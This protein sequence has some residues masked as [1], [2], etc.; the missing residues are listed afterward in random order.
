M[1][2][3]NDIFICMELV[4]RWKAWKH[5]CHVDPR[6]SDITPHLSAS[7][8]LFFN[9]FLFLW[10]LAC[11]N[12]GFW[13]AFLGNRGHGGRSMACYGCA[14]DYWFG[15]MLSCRTWCYSGLLCAFGRTDNSLG[16]GLRS[17]VSFTAWLGLGYSDACILR[18]LR[19]FVLQPSFYTTVRFTAFLICRWRLCFCSAG[20]FECFRAR[21]GLP[22]QLCW[23]L[24]TASILPQ[25][26]YWVVLFV[27]LKQNNENRLN[28][29][30][31]KKTFLEGTSIQNS[32][33]N[34]SYHE[35]GPVVE[36]DL[37]VHDELQNAAFL[38]VQQFT[39]GALYL[40][41]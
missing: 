38:L 27:V 41:V 26:V 19:L 3:N 12:L 29:H 39:A 22:R 32:Q 16:S 37:L 13:F 35:S 23:G 15:L 21:H 31:W 10:P 2:Y 14:V 5:L 17:L 11:F 18:V 24:V 28:M 1:F 30:Q 9:L 6:W 4:N 40:S 25:D 34:S 33:S 20:R 36:G 7:V 8:C